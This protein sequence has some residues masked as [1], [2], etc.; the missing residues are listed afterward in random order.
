MQEDEEF[1]EVW[2]NYQITKVQKDTFD[3]L[4]AIADG[5]TDR[6][7]AVRPRPADRGAQGQQE[8][9]PALE[10]FDQLCLHFCIALPNHELGDYEYEIVLEIW[11]YDSNSMMR[12]MKRVELLDDFSGT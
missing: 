5:I 12:S 9:N 2:L 11:E 8:K 4:V 3:V 10:K 1:E 6:G 7:E